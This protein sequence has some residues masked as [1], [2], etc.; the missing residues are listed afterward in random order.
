MPTITEIMA[1]DHRKCDD[2]FTQAEECIAAG[3]WDRGSPL[4]MTFLSK[5]EE[6]FRKEEEVLFPKFEQTTGQTVGPIQVM[7]SEHTQMRQLFKDMQSALEKQDK[8]HFLGL[9][10]TLMMIMQQHNMK[11]EQI[12]Y[13]MADQVF[14]SIADEIL[15]AMGDFD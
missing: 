8:Q 10:E 5:T 7:K 2:S 1:A 3:D 12:L 6:H 13:R 9:A 15:Q 11:E 4:F 14:G